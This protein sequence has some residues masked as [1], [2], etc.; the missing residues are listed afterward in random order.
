MREKNTLHYGCEFSLLEDVQYVGQ[1]A[2]IAAHVHYR[3]GSAL[4]LI[5]R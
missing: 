5:L 4:P 1:C 3:G 2:T